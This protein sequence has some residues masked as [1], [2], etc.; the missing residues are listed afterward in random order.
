MHIGIGSA[1]TETTNEAKDSGALKGYTPDVVDFIRRCDNVEEVKEII[2]FLEKRCEI[3]HEYAIKLRTQLLEKG[4]RS[5]GSKKGDGYYF[6][7]P[8]V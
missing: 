7:Q 3:S 2:N 4:M 5:F 6:K 1:R 8:K